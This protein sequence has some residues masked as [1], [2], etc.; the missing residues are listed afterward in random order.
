MKSIR[1][2]GA[3]AV[4]AALAAPAAASAHPSVYTSQAQ[5]V[6]D[7]TQPTVLTPQTRYVVANHG[8]TYVLRESNGDF[9]GS[10][11]GVFDY[12]SL[13][14]AYRATLATWDDLRNAGAT[15][16]QAHA[17]CRVPQL[18]TEAAIKSWQGTDPFYAY[19]PFQ[20]TSAGLEDDPATWIPK[21]KELT[22]GAVDLSTISTAAAAEAACEGLPGA[23]AD[24][25]VPA[26]VTQSTNEAFNSGLIEHTT[27]PLAA[28]IAGLKSTA[29]TNATALTTLQGLLD[30]AKAEIARLTA[31]VTPLKVTLP[32]ATAKAKT[33]AKQ[34]AT[35]TVTGLAG[36]STI[37]E[38]SVSEQRARKL[39]LKSSVLASKKATIGSDGTATVTLK[40]G[41][42]ARK[43]LKKLKKSVAMTVT[44]VSADRIATASGTLTR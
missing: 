36:A 12:K 27:E 19:V 26:D 5:V 9:D 4:A 35:A 13:P 41:K 38:L 10:N 8:F 22:A 33:I 1:I 44:A 23:N 21:V 29:A 14:G 3:L 31:A 32:S 16:A 17:T 15:N 34:G 25:Y 18:E 20:Q 40:P 37:V 39:K 6:E 7:E 11:R 28:E 2:A 43:A 42:A 30:A 24:S